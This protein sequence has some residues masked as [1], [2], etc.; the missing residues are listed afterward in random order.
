MSTGEIHGY[1]PFGEGEPSPGSMD[2][3]SPTPMTGPAKRKRTLSSSSDF[4][5]PVHLQ[6]LTQ[7]SPVP[8]ASE[9]LP[10]ID[11]FHP[12]NQLGALQHQTHSLPSMATSTQYPAQQ[13][14]PVSASSEVSYRAQQ[15]PNGVFW[16][17]KVPDFGGRRTSSNVAFEGA[18][19]YPAAFSGGQKQQVASF[20]WDEDVVN[21]CVS[22]PYLLSELL[23]SVDHL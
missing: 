18:S 8:R 1:G 23:A 22:R 7:H 15:S 5:A 10:P 14:P 21:Q 2:T 20:E 19:E 6:P 13:T 3:S 4:H 12:T 17:G 16:K 11:S 9:R